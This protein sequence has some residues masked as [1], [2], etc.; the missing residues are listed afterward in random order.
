MKYLIKLKNNNSDN[1][2]ENCIKII[3]NSDET[4]LLGTT[5]EIQDVLIVNRPVFNDNNKYHIKLLLHE[6]LNKS[7]KCIL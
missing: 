2:D 3:F 5:I 1:Y 7:A 4:V 6:C